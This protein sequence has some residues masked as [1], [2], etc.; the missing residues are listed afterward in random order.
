MGGGSYDPARAGSRGRNLRPRE[1]TG[2]GRAATIIAP[3]EAGE[4]GG[5]SGNCPVGSLRAWVGVG[6]GGVGR[7]RL[8]FL[9]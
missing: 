5:G 2:V 1:T 9:R 6:A 8:C 4:R 3:A 7:Q